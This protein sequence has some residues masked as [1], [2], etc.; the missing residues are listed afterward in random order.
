MEAAAQMA[1]PAAHPATA[2]SRLFCEPAK[3][4][5]LQN[6]FACPIHE[7][8]KL[9]SLGIILNILYEYEEHENEKKKNEDAF[10]FSVL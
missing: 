7:S 5:W 3:A 6:S 8:N 9:S 10:N 2:H 4:P 1:T